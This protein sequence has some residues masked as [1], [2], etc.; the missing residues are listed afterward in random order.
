MKRAADTFDVCLLASHIPASI[1]ISSFN[2]TL[3]ISGEG[4]N[5]TRPLL[6]IESPNACAVDAP[7]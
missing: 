3:Q 1:A 7:G 5:T 4:H 2:A 6:T